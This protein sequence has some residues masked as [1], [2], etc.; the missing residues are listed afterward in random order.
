[1]TRDGRRLSASRQWRQTAILAWRDFIHEWKVSLCLI[2]ALGA[3]LAPLL[4][5]FGLKS[6]IVTTMTERL[7][8]DPRNLEVIIKGNSRVD[9]EW[10]DALRHRSDVG[11]VLPRT[12]SLA[13]TADLVGVDQRAAPNIDMIPTAAGDPLVPEGLPAPTG[14]GQ[15]ILSHTV[16]AKLDA[17][18]GDQVDAFVRRRYEGASEAV[19]I[20]LTVVG[21]LTEASFARDAA[22]LSLALLEATEDYRDGLKVP[23]LGADTGTAPP[24]RDR[25][26]AGV[27]LYAASL[28]D[29]ASLAAHV[30]SRGYD[31]VTRAKDIETV[32]AIDRVLTFIFFVIAGVGITGFLLSLAASLW[33]N[34]DR[35]RRDLAM[36][37]LLGLGI[38]PLMAFPAMQAAIVAAG[39]GVLSL[40]LYALVSTVFNT[41]LASNL[42]REEF[43]S[44]LFIGDA[45]VAMLL[46]IAFALG[47]SAVGGYRVAQID[48]AE[49]L[50]EP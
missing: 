12:R 37:R 27:R 1:M 50:R 6:G 34:V 11:F 40:G 5:L 14:L 17:E 29:V 24:E 39:G 20:P 13:A 45:V 36:L 3:V 38:G 46:T 48:P 41:V 28:D 21:V 35:K 9:Q 32:K 23:E 25:T 15:V 18:I 47:A 26:Y 31:V 16:A 49:S 10:V 19:T 44:R 30:R 8:A 4:V 7:K 2:L 43:V 42:E 22:F 33:A